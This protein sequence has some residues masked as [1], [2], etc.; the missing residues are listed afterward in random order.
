MTE[1]TL[2]RLHNVAR[3]PGDIRDACVSEQA[4]LTRNGFRLPPQ[5]AQHDTPPVCARS[6][7]LMLRCQPAML[8]TVVP[9]R[10]YGDGNCLFRAVST[11]IFGHEAAHAVIRLM[12]A[13]EVGTHR[14]LYDANSPSRHEVLKHPLVVVPPYVEVFR[15]LTTDGADSCIVSLLAVSAA[16]GVVI[17]SYY[18]PGLSELPSPLTTTVSPRY[19]SAYRRVSVLWTTT[20]AV[21]PTGPLNINHFVPLF[22]RRPAAVPNVADD[23]DDADKD[24]PLGPAVDSVDSDDCI[25]VIDDSPT[26]APSDDAVVLDNAAADDDLRDGHQTPPPK[27]RRRR[28]Q[29]RKFFPDADIDDSRHHSHVT[30]KSS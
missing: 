22:T 21:S 26:A 7:Q 29:R 4:R 17:D 15:E 16:L 11:S 30:E 18:P 20:D 13:I 8:E 19:E 23:D 14:E 25:Q 27:R 1:S 10:T 9:A 28:R 6:V 24:S 3:T 2:R 5:C 12:A